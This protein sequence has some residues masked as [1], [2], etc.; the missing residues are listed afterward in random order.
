MPLLCEFFSRSESGLGQFFLKPRGPWGERARA[1]AARRQ[2][3]RFRGRGSRAGRRGPRRPA[4]EPRR[5]AGSA[6]PGG[7]PRRPAKVRRRSARVESAPVGAGAVARRR[8][9]LRPGG[10]GAAPG[11][12][13]D[14]PPGEGTASA[15]AGAVAARR[16][17]G[18]GRRGARGHPAREPRRPD[19]VPCRSAR[20][21]CRS[22]RVSMA[23]DDECC[24]PVGTG[25]APGG[26]AWSRPACA[27]RRRG[28]IG[29]GRGREERSGYLGRRFAPP[30]APPPSP[31]I[32]RRM[33]WA[34]AFS[35]ASLAVWWWIFAFHLPSG[36][37]SK[38]TSVWRMAIAAVRTAAVSTRP[39]LKV[40]RGGFE[41]GVEGVPRVFGVL[42]G[43]GEGARAGSCGGVGAGASG[44]DRRRRRRLGEVV[45]CRLVGGGA[46]SAGPRGW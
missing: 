43:Q 9:A 16:R 11:G 7:E 23:R 26:A 3:G 22:A 29:A 20:V 34:M 28:W 37:R 5:P 30:P 31:G 46:R 12:A 33:A 21:E 24:A 25:A 10:T 40:E 1:P 41:E 42:G 14:A 44:W 15:G 4:R 38:V 19:Q 2:K 8:R 35:R 18:V 36:L 13:G 32:A 17:C 27:A 39:G 45:R 6:S